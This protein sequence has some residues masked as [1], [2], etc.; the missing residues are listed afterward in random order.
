MYFGPFALIFVRSFG[1]AGV[2][3]LAAAATFATAVPLY[4]FR[5]PPSVRAKT[6]VFAE[7]VTPTPNTDC[8]VNALVMV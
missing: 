3:S 7:S 5:F 8:V 4:C 1:G 2:A 6:D